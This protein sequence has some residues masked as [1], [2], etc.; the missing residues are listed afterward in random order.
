MPPE[1]K[2]EL[3]ESYERDVKGKTEEQRRELW[4]KYLR[5]LFVEDDDLRIFLDARNIARL[6]GFTLAT[7]Y[8][9]RERIAPE[10]FV[11]EFFFGIQSVCVDVYVGQLNRAG[12]VV[13]DTS[14][15]RFLTLRHEIA[16]EVLQVHDSVDSDDKT[17]VCVAMAKVW[18]RFV[19]LLHAAYRLPTVEQL[20][21][22]V[23][24][25]SEAEQ[26]ALDLDDYE[27]PITP[28]QRLRW[29]RL[30]GPGAVRP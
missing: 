3:D 13:I 27:T 21:P 6:N 29:E 10:S 28:R 2:R 17:E 24:Y 20:K 8:L 26:T 15:E 12:V 7:K 1:R 14:E 19:E 18:H 30:I 9:E 25:E 11:R 16:F 23:R 5:D 22:W 4:L